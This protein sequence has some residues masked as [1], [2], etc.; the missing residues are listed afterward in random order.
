MAEPTYTI[1]ALDRSTWP[2]FAALVEANNGIFGGC[3]CMGFHPEGGDKAAT[4][5]LNREREAGTRSCRDC[6][7]SARLRW[8]RLPR[9]V[10]VRAAR[11]AA[12]H[13]EP[14]GVRAGPYDTAGLADR[15]LLRR[16]G[17]PPGGRRGRSAH[18]RARSD[19][20]IGRRDRRG[21]PRG[22]R[23]GACRL[24]LQ[25]GAVFLREARVRPRPQD[26]QAPLGRHHRGRTVIAVAWLTCPARRPSRPRGLCRPSDVIL[27]GPDLSV[28]DLLDHPHTKFRTDRRL[29]R[30]YPCSSR[31]EISEISSTGRPPARAGVVAGACERLR[32]GP[33]AQ[34]RSGQRRP[35]RA[36]S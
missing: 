33:P 1:K 30:A 25:R 18:R 3:W 15:L 35:G 9:L 12:T 32:H 36:S 11:R 34:A 14:R 21:L 13:Q 8:R 27:A 26:R 28:A 10:S 4:A 16:E 29:P 24:P 20:P 31:P 6:A 23:L 2:A 19:R 7:C 5:A 22:R 17:P